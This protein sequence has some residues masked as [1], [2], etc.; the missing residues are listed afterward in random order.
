MLHWIRSLHWEGKGKRKTGSLNQPKEPV[1]VPKQEGLD[2]S[3]KAKGTTVP[4]PLKFQGPPPKLGD[5]APT[6]IAKQPVILKV[7]AGASI[8]ADQPKPKVETPPKAEQLGA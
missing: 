2:P 1:P 7:K 4:T 8:V 3:G 5:V 6:V